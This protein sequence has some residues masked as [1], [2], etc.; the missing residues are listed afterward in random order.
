M[1]YSLPVPYIPASDERKAELE[2]IFRE[3]NLALQTYAKKSGLDRDRLRGLILS[4][5]SSEGV[6]IAQEDVEKIR[7]AKDSEWEALCAFSNLIVKIVNRWTP[8]T[9]D[10]S[11]CAE[12]L[13]NEAIAAALK[14]IRGFT[15]EEFRLCTFVHVCVSRK[16]SELCI[17]SGSASR[18]PRSLAKLKMQYIKLAGE[19][20]AT[21]DGIVQR[22]GLSEKQVSELIFALRGVTNDPEN[23]DCGMRVVDESEEIQQDGRIMSVVKNLDLS[24]LERAVLEGFLSSG[25][26]MGLSSV[27]KKL[28]NPNTKKPYSRM[29]FSFAWA[30][31][32]EKIAKAYADAA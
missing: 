26:K 7:L 30:R 11:L 22:M 23:L 29:A 32:K 19:E 4:G 20:G 10:L 9:C 12:D 8:K 25:S 15:Q 21:F 28:I 17:K 6:R 14:A 3:G 2:S 16:L 18:I 1:K 13:G 27:S 31:V 5:R 24:E